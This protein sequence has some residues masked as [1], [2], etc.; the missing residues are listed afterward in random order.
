MTLAIEELVRYH[1]IVLLP[2]RVTRDLEFEGACLREGDQVV[3]PTQA[4]NRDPQQFAEPNTLDITRS[5][6][7]HLAFGGGI[8]YCLGAPLARLEG[9]IAFTTLARRMPNLQLAAD[10]VIYGANYTLRG[11]EALPVRF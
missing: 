7:R 5:N 8:H 11:L 1:S 6:N 4:C 9:E 10:K 3:C 2:R